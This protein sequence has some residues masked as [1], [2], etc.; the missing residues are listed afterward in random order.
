MNDQTSSQRTRHSIL[1][2]LST[3]TVILTG[4]ALH[5]TAAFMVPVVFS[6]FLALLVAP[7]DRMVS[8]RVPDKVSW[9]GHLAAIGAV[10]VALLVFAAMI[11]VAAQQVVERFPVSSSSGLLPEFGQE[12]RDPTGGS[13]S[14]AGA[15]GSDRATPSYGMM[16]GLRNL[17]PDAGSTIIENLGSWAS[18]I[19]MQILRAASSALFAT[20]LVIFL[21]LIMLIEA[22]NWQRKIAAVSDGGTR[23]DVHESTAVIASLLRRYLLA[24]TILGVVTAI[25]YVAWLW[26]FG[27]DLLVVWALLTVLLN[28]IPTLGSLISG[29]LPVLYALVQKDPG[30]AVMVGAGIFVIEQVMGNYVDPRVQGR[31]VSLSSLV[32]LITLLVW[33][34]IWGIAGAILA[35][36]V[37]IA[38]MIIC[39]HIGPLRPFALMLSDETDMEGLDQRASGSGG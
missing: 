26:I 30:T 25:L 11:W 39:A 31:Q 9:L 1:F 33:G 34:W 15:P 20:V 23:R 3:V 32:V 6:V 12:I 18:G 28:Y 37:T 21:T 36:P 10:V 24:R 29:V 14:G 5:A 27:I 8:E 4:W 17:L 22:P 38:A 35:V 7:L 2:L 19:A 13:A 16:E